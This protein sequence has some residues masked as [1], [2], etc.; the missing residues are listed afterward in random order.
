LQRD[1][2]KPEYSLE[3]RGDIVDRALKTLA[4]TMSL[5]GLPGRVAELLRTE[6]WRE[7]ILPGMDA[8]AHHDTFAAFVVALPPDGLGTD[9]RTLKNLCRDDVTV[10]DAIDQATKGEAGRPKGDAETLYNIQGF[11]AGTSRDRALR[12]LREHRPDLHEKV[13]AGELSAHAAAV[14]AGFRKRTVTVPCEPEGFAKAITR[15]L[16]QDQIRELMDL[17][18]A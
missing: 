16:N 1:G 10:C 17:L 7:F 4:G 8:P 5:Q 11:P 18:D 2:S 3:I 15:H 9:L 12:Q 6:A 13:L 14:Q